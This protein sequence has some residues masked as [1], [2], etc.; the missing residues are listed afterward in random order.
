MI[1]SAKHTFYSSVIKENSGNS[2]LFFKTI[3]KH[4]SGP[5]NCSLSESF[6]EYFSDKID[7]TL[8]DGQVISWNVS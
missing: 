4:P 3:E 6:V 1:D 7:G 8:H 5:N 2:G